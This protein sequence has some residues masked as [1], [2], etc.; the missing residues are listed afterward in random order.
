MR[1][2]KERDGQKTVVEYWRAQYPKL[3]RCLQAS[4]S[5]AVLGGNIKARA[6]QMS[7]LKACGLVVGQADLFLSIAKQ[8]YHGLYI[9]MKSLKGQLS[10]EQEAFIDDM[11]AQGYAAMPCFGADEA[12]EAIKGYMK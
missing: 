6:M 4:S 11:Q 1:K 8:G 12:I 5:G 3:W 7:S 9:E 2:V 10:A